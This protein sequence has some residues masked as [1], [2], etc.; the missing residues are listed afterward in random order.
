MA[1]KKQ[2][3]K[4]IDG[5][6]KNPKGKKPA[7]KAPFAT[8]EDNAI[9]KES[10]IKETAASEDDDSVVV[11][12]EDTT[13]AVIE[14]DNLESP[15]NISNK[16]SASKTP[17]AKASNLSNAT[18]PSEPAVEVDEQETEPNDLETRA[19]EITG[20]P[21]VNSD[22]DNG[23]IS[24]AILE[25]DVIDKNLDNIINDIEN[26]TKNKSDIK[27]DTK[28]FDSRSL[29]E[30]AAVD[31]IARKE[32]ESNMTKSSKSTNTKSDNKKSNAKDR[33]RGNAKPF[34]IISR[35]LA[36]GTAVAVAA[37]AVRIATTGIVPNKYLIPGIVISAAVLIFYLFKAFRNKTRIPV[38]I[39]L[40]LIGIV[41][42]VASVFGFIKIDETMAFLNNNFTDNK[43]YSIYNVIVNKKSN[44]N[45][46]SDV[47]GKAFHSISDFIDTEKLESAVKDQASA[48]VA[49]EDGITS[50]LNNALNDTTY[51]ALLNSGTWDATLDTEDGK[52]YNEGLK[53]IGEIKVE[54]EKKKNTSTSNLT[55]QSFT[56]YLSG[57][58]TRSGL[59]LDRS[60][61]DVNMVITVNP[62]TK[63]ILMSTIP[64]DYYVQ[65]HGT[66]GLP[67]KLTH[68]GSLGG[69]ELSMETIDDLLNINFDRYIRVNFNFVIDLVNAIG[70]ITVY[71]DVDHDITAWTDS[72][73]T[74]HPGNNQVDGR[75]A[76][77]FARER[78][79]YS[80]GDR[81]RG[82]NQEQVIQKI[83]E[84]VTSSSTLI[85]KYSSILD[86]LSGSFDTDITTDDITSFAN[87]Q[88]SDMAKWNINTYNLDGTGG[89][90]YTY[91][92]PNQ[93]LY[94]MFP[95]VNTVDTA[96]QKIQE[97]LTGSLPEPAAE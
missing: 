22:I 16:K 34:R 58:D 36:I 49:Y 10:I 38:L 2:K 84:K 77:A 87:M 61:S 53:I 52:K 8:E 76:L 6:V 64:R 17:E 68:A 40:N 37:L 14:A 57:I 59:M 43:E 89:M 23:L 45:S 96:K 88:L 92:Y 9:I 79:A 11:A 32:E 50:L 60:L 75:C 30:D 31:S 71:S 26:E 97:V 39:I 69:I 35:L 51:I 55:E 73:C 41:I 44:Y 47:K 95:D 83:F 86:A 54:V 46:L 66:T 65:L 18:M 91:S 42:S 4:V 27:T 20:R 5:V 19:E 62:K 72:S 93:K 29:A 25:E 90:A 81:H 12:T 85:S 94:V 82:R 28:R 56:V 1:T 48:T 80:D 74:F 13:V 24:D 3:K 78:Y 21:E 67:D 15:K 33:S 70:G 7:R 63:N